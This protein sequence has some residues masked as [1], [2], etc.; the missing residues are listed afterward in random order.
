MG[1]KQRDAL[2]RGPRTPHTQDRTGH[3]LDMVFTNL[4]FA[5]TTL[6]NHFEFGSDRYTLFTV[7]PRRGIIRGSR[8]SEDGS[9]PG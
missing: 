9:T 6:A 4:P 2:L 5:E 8:A 7:V 3:M 1:N